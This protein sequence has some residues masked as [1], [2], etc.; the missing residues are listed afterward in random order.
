MNNMDKKYNFEYDL[1]KKL[2]ELNLMEESKGILDKI[3][4]EYLIK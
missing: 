3:Y 4:E 1:K 2:T